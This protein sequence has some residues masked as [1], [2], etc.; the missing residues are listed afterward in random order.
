MLLVSKTFV[1]RS[2]KKFNM[3]ILIFAVM[4]C[5]VLI[6]AYASTNYLWSA[7]TT[8]AISTFSPYIKVYYGNQEVTSINFGNLVPGASVGIPL[9]IVNTH[10]NATFYFINWNSTLRELT[11][12]IMDG[13]GFWDIKLK[14]PISIEPGGYRE[15][16]YRI[17]VA[18]DCPLATYTW[19]LYLYGPG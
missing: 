14:W 18:S 6:S 15:T 13:W 19:T 7:P 11:N 9:R 3:K 16:E 8:V 10:P 5:L 17:T 12:K 4:C 2:S 1:G